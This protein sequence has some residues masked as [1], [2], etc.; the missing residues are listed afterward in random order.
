[1]R[2]LIA[3]ASKHGGTYGI[4]TRL[5]TTLGDL[6]HEANVM[7]IDGSRCPD[8]YDAYVIGAA[9]Y[10]GHWMKAGRQFVHDNLITLRAKPVW[11]FS[12]GP[13]GE[14]A[15]DEA[16]EAVDHAVSQPEDVGVLAGAREHKVFAGRLFRKELGPIERIAAAAVHAPEGDFRDWAEID[17]WAAHID[18]ELRQLAHT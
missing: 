11:M 12:S 8:G 13:L 15:A 2:I 7:T 1:M 14:D 4:A 17:E 9:V 18:T 5:R 3:V 6:G 16:D 10:G